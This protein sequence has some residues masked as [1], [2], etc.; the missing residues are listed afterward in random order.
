MRA[1]ARLA[2]VEVA[3]LFWVGT[4]C[5]AR[6]SEYLLWSEFFSHGRG[7]ISQTLLRRRHAS[8]QQV[9]TMIPA[10]AAF[11][12]PRAA[13][14][15]GPVGSDCYFSF[16]A[17]LTIRAAAWLVSSRLQTC[18]SNCW[19]MEARAFANWPTTRRSAGNCLL[20][21][22]QTPSPGTPLVSCTILSLRLGI[23]TVSHRH[24]FSLSFAITRLSPCGSVRGWPVV[25][26]HLSPFAAPHI[27]QGTLS[28]LLR[29]SFFM[30]KIMPQ[31]QVAGML[32]IEQ[33]LTS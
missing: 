2:S 8:A 30:G 12:S 11:L 3:P 31:P 27:G 19:S 1:V 15:L 23:W 21:C 33:L 22:S 13:E 14:S 25:S 9:T 32:N 16:G 18:A 20:Q 24:Y 7:T 28:T 5:R 29:L 10:A 6:D 17:S 4:T 26:S